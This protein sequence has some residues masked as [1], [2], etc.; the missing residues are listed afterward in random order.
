LASTLRNCIAG[1]KSVSFIDDLIEFRIQGVYLAVL[2][3]QL[4]L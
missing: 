1:V 4:A 3:E 2:L